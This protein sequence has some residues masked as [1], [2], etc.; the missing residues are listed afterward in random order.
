MCVLGFDS[1]V[2][3]RPVEITNFAGRYIDPE[4][5]AIN[6]IIVNIVLRPFLIH[7]GDILKQND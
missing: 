1:F 2:S 4:G 3:I 6:N 7:N 5:T